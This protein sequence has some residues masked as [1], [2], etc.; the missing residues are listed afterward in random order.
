MNNIYE[1]TAASLREL[2]D[3]AK[4]EEGDLVVIGGSSSEIRGGRIGKDSSAEV[5]RE[6]IR[7]VLDVAKEYHVVLAIQCCEHLNRAL[8]V[9]KETARRYGLRRV[10]VRP[11]LH[12][13]GA[14]A[15][16]AMEM[17]AE[18]VV[19]EAIQ[20]HG[21]ID[22]GT[23]LIGMHLRPVVVPVRLEHNR[24]GEAPVVGARTRFPLIG[25]ERARYE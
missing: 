13:G 14:L 20:A 6:V 15:T 23:T 18:P 25:G 21:G 10:Q 16:N 17:F 24:I 8:V 4:F 22:I 1:E 5:G 3:V 11:W 19:V 2:C 9:E 7:A 12:A